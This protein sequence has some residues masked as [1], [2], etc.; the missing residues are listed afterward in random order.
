[1]IKIGDE[2]VAMKGS[3]DNN[4]YIY[5]HG[6]YKGREVIN[7]V[8]EDDRKIVGSLDATKIDLNGEECFGFECWWVAKKQFDKMEKCGRQIKVVPVDFKTK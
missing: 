7:L 5:G 1:M 8:D 3:D 2:V 6:T 4:I